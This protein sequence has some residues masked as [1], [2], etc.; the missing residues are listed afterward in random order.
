MLIVL[1]VVAC[2]TAYVT[3]AVLTFDYLPD[4]SSIE[5]R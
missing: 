1:I 3:L 4:R 2:V 5:L